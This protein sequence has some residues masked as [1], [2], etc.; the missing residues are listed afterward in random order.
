VLGCFEEGSEIAFSIKARNFF[1]SWEELVASKT[2]GYTK[3]LLQ[4]CP[5]DCILFKLVLCVRSWLFLRLNSVS[6]WYCWWM[7][8]LK[9]SGKKMTRLK[10]GTIFLE[11]LRNTK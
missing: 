10:K 9:L 5:L 3:Y 7:V 1:T 8:K 4:C 2:D 11:V 6:V